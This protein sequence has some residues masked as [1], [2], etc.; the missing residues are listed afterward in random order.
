MN[1]AFTSLAP[2]LQAY[3]QQTMD[4]HP[5]NN[6]LADYAKCRDLDP[7]RYQLRAPMPPPAPPQAKTRTPR[8]RKHPGHQSAATT[9]VPPPAD[10]PGVKAQLGLDRGG[11][12]MSPNFV[13]VGVIL[14]DGR[15]TAA[16][17]P[18]SPR[19]WSSSRSR[20]GVSRDPGPMADML[21]T[22][23]TG[24]TRQTAPLA[25]V[26]LA[27][28]PISSRSMPEA[29]EETAELYRRDRYIALRLAGRQDGRD[30]GD[31]HFPGVRPTRSSTRG[32]SPGTA[33]DR[34]GGALARTQ[35][36]RRGLDQRQVVLQGTCRLPRRPDRRGWGPGRRL[37]VAEQEHERP[38]L[39]RASEPRG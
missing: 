9:N 27:T 3:A 39:R 5:L 22:S 32:S 2:V 26:V 31:P 33:V 24:R 8:T 17:P 30:A 11:P 23:I 13:P 20:P 15:W 1:E 18:A 25:R 14:P 6:L 38:W 10:P 21:P 7:A 29:A 4:M 35:A 34:P 36:R 19:M 28:L 16:D 12:D 37:R